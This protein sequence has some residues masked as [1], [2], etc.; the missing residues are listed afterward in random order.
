MK[1]SILEVIIILFLFGCKTEREGIPK[2]VLI[3][4]E[5]SA[6]CPMRLIQQDMIM[7]YMCDSRTKLDKQHSDWNGNQ[8]D[9][10]A[11]M[12]GISYVKEKKLSFSTLAPLFT[13]LSLQAGTDKR[14]LTDSIM[15]YALSEIEK[16]RANGPEH[17][18]FCRSRI[19]YFRGMFLSEGDGSG[20]LSYSPWH[21]KYDKQL[22]FHEKRFEDFLLK[23]VAQNNYPTNQW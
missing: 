2:N 22:R 5:S 10:A 4:S 6:S 21:E 14:I 1:K 23:Q 7:K 11:I 9:S 17:A 19:I 8:L 15:S 13:L 16:M 3:D 12:E 18:Q 20:S